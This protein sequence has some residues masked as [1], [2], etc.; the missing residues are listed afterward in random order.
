MKLKTKNK[1]KIKETKEVEDIPINV[2]TISN[3]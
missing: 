1:E 2:S 3:I